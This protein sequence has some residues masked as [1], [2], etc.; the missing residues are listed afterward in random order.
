MA[1]EVS[2]YKKKAKKWRNKI[3]K[4]SKAE[5]IPVEEVEKRFA[6]EHERITKDD[7]DELQK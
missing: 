6:E 7:V 2:K 3:N 1:C 4:I 5:N